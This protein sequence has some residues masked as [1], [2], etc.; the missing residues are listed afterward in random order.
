M[1][2]TKPRPV[3]LRPGPLDLYVVR[4]DEFKLRLQFFDSDDL[5]MDISGW[6]L[7]A[8][9]RNTY[10]GA[11]LATFGLDSTGLPSNEVNLVLSDAQTGVIGEGVYP[12][13]LQR[14]A[15]GQVI[16]TMLAG[17]VVVSPDVTEAP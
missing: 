9:M 10:Q 12:W 14:F 16:R 13:D 11:L 17:V 2:R 4:G 3:G 8:Q 6:T 5:P 15:G 7:Q 1:Q